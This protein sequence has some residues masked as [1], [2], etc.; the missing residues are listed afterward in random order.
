MKL[1]E[2]MN[3]TKARVS[4]NCQYDYYDCFGNNASVIEFKDADGLY[5]ATCVYDTVTHDVYQITAEVPGQQQHF[6]WLAPQW[7]M[8]YINQCKKHNVN[9]D[10][11]IDDIK[12][13]NIIMGGI[14]L[15][16]LADIGDTYYDNLPIKLDM[17]GTIGSAKL[18]FKE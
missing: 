8:N 3:A 13:E 11:V 2:V 10:I 14:M 17:P 9:P 5:C 7:Q 1:L 16:Y 18:V 12:Y 4:T 15:A 6:Q